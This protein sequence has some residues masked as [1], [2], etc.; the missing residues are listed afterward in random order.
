MDVDR[1]GTLSWQELLYSS[2]Q[3]EEF[4]ML[5]DLMDFSESDMPL[6]FN[7][8]DLDCSNQIDYAEFGR[9][10]EKLQQQ[11]TKVSAAI[12][13]HFAEMAATTGK[14]CESKLDRQE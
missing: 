13:M 4:K 14:R 6:F 12:G 2:S 7:M 1:S 5:L 9:M 3:H 10:L 8:V 11:N